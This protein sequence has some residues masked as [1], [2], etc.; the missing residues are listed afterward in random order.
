MRKSLS[1]QKCALHAPSAALRHALL[2]A[3]DDGSID[4]NGVTIK[5]EKRSDQCLIVASDVPLMITKP[6]GATALGAPIGTN[7]FAQ[8]W[9]G[10]QWGT[11]DRVMLDRIKR[12]ADT[13]SALCALRVLACSKS[14]YLMRSAPP[15]IMPDRMQ[16]WG[17]ALLQVVSALLATR[18]MT[19]LA[20]A[21]LRVEPVRGGA[22]APGAAS[23]PSTS[24]PRPRAPCCAIR[25]CAPHPQART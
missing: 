17:S 16:R 6:R 12:M 4:A 13:Q 25:I 18:S 5:L 11:E 2:E 20:A 19:P 7:A 23:L 9:L 15:P 21:L 24:A 14:A 10:Q 1:G 3:A 22:G 8:E